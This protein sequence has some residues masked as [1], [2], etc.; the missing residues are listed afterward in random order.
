MKITAVSCLF[1]VLLSGCASFEPQPLSPADTIA[2]YESRTVDN[3]DLQAFIQKNIQHELPAWPLPQWDFDLLTLIALYYHP[4]LDVARA[5]WNVAQAGIATAGMRPNPGINVNTQRNADAPSGISPW[6][7][8]LNLD[9]PVETAGKRGYRIDQAQYLSEAAR[10]A[11]AGT[12]WQVRSRVRSTLLDMYFAEQTQTVLL[13]QQN[14]QQNNVALLEHR[15]ALGMASQPEVTQARIALHQTTLAFNETQKL[16]ADARAK[17][18]SALGVS[19]K[20]IENISISS[21]LF[22]HIP[23]L[24]AGDVR[25]QALLGRPD[26]LSALAEYAASQSALQLEIAKQYPNLNLGPGYTWDAGARKWSLGLSLTLPIFN[27]NQ[28]PIA[29]AKARRLQAMANFNATQ[30]RV[31]GEIDAAL[32]GYQFIQTK[33]AAADALLAEQHKQIK[34]MMASFKA[35]ATDKVALLGTQLEMSQIELS[36]IDVLAKTQQ[37]LGALEDAVQQPLIAPALLPDAI[38]ENPRHTKENNK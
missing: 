26:I 38:Q 14:L 35:G 11:I 25:Q 24:P 37:A 6:I 19:S 33:L 9:I 21:D 36:R 17:L 7:L 32:T 10:L 5:K 2:S 8:G 4:D 23:E 30:A 31:I 15:L 18:A 29:E 12:A 1:I 27:Q 13:Q 20:A 16:Q 3:P 28:G 34:N 22:T